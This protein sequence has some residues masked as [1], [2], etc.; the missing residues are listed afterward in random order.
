MM[1]LITPELWEERRYR[2]VEPNI[3]E[4]IVIS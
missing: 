1:G 4:G 2:Q 3:N